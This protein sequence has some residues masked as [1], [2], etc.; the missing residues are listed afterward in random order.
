M[1]AS[2]PRSS[3]WTH[4][5]A[6]PA[7]S[8]MARGRRPEAC[9]WGVGGRLQTG[10]SRA[11]AAHFACASRRLANRGESEFSVAPRPLQ[12]GGEADV[13][14]TRCLVARAPHGAPSLPSGGAPSQPL[15]GRR[16]ARGLPNSLPSTKRRALAIKQPTAR[17]AASPAQDRSWRAAR[18]PPCSRTRRSASAGSS[19]ALP[20]PASAA[21]VR[22]GES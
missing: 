14:R 6:Y 5:R 21:L 9:M 12:P 20:I 7:M 13:A 18:R 2:P 22:E 10:A 3:S 11:A 19:P 1:L 8:F 4:T 16:R 15:G 17:Q